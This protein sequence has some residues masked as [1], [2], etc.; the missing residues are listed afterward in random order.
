MVGGG[1]DYYGETAER[2]QR[3]VVETARQLAATG[4]FI[5]YTG[6]MPGIGDDFARAFVEAGGSVVDIVSS[7]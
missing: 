2:D 1:Q 3:V 6:G 5:V 7:E 4:K